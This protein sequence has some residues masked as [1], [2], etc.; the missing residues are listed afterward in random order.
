[1]LG[2]NQS[3]VNRIESL[4]HQKYAL[5]QL[6]KMQEASSTLVNTGQALT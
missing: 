1:M 4:E 2:I 5:L 3:I 6:Q